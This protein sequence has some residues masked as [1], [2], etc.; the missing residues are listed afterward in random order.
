MFLF[1]FSVCFWLTCTFA[2]NSVLF[3][4]TFL[5][6]ILKLVTFC[7]GSLEFVF[8]WFTSLL[9]EFVLWIWAFTEVS[10]KEVLAVSG[11]LF[12]WTFDKTSTSTLFETMLGLS[13]FS[14]TVFLLGLL[15]FSKL[16]LSVL[17]RGFWLLIATLIFKL[18]CEDVSLTFSLLASSL[19]LVFALSA[20]LSLV[21]LNLCGNLFC[22]LGFC[23]FSTTASFLISDLGTGGG[24]FFK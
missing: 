23:W 20:F 3:V 22:G 16:F 1:K 12:F 8:T 9:F 19:L 24:F 6:G 2:L 15:L 4:S 11:E 18:C 7:F 5:L 10:L 17:F 14:C 13:S 21:V